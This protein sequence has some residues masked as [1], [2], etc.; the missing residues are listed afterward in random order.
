MSFDALK[1]YLTDGSFFIYA[2]II[3]YCEIYSVTHYISLNTIKED[4]FQL[5]QEKFAKKA[6]YPK[7]CHFRFQTCKMTHQIHFHMPKWKIDIGHNKDYFSNLKSIVD[8]LN[9]I[10][11]GK[12][13]SCFF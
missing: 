3:F 9:Y 10:K 5:P 13:P 1:H 8:L 4:L 7:F 11:R 6:A 2:T 12:M